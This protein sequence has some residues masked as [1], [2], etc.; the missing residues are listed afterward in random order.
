MLMMLATRRLLID[1]ERYELATETYAVLTTYN[2][3]F[4]T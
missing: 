2:A 4:R 3:R 1:A